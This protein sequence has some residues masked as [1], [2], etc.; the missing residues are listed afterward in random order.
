MSKLVCWA[1]FDS[2]TG[3]YMSTARHYFADK[4]DIY[5]VGLS[6]YGKNTDHYVNFDL[7]DFS[8]LFGGGQYRRQVAQNFTSTGHHCR[9]PT[10]RIVVAYDWDK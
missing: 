6:H 9:E 3:D 2:E 4:I 8:E 5:G 1:L 7:S 10:M